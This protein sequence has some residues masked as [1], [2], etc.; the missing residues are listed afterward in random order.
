MQNSQKSAPLAHLLH[1]VTIVLTFENLSRGHFPEWYSAVA[2]DGY[3]DVGSL[4][5]WPA[6]GV[7]PMRELGRERESLK[8]RFTITDNKFSLYLTL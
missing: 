8:E 6:T 1:K 7:H 5:G 4:A 3:A 2:D